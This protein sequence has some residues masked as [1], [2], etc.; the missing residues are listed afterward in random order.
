[1][2]M[3]GVFA[4]LTFGGYAQSLDGMYSSMQADDEE[5]ANLA[6]LWI[7][8]RSAVWILDQVDGFCAVLG[9]QLTGED[10]IIHTIDLCEGR[11]VL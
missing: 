1:M 7:D 8:N 3:V 2:V 11:T 4:G 10:G 9:T 6:D 5:G